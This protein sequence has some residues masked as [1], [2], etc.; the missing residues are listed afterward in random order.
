MTPGPVFLTGATGFTGARLLD[1]MLEKEIPLRALY[2]NP[3][4][5]NELPTENVDW[6]AGDL[7]NV[8]HLT[9]LMRG[10]SA[11]INIASLGFG[12][13]P[14]IVAAAQRAG[15]RRAIF[16][17]T[18]AVFT[19]LNAASKSVRL[20]AE[21]CIRASE[22]DWTILRPTMIYGSPLDR[23]IW[24]LIHWLR[25]LPVLPILGDGTRLM[26]PIFVDDLAAAIA[27]CLENPATIHKIYNLAGLEPLTY[28]EIVQ[29][30]AAGLGRKVWLPVIPSMP[31]IAFLRMMERLRLPFPLKSEQVERL[32]EDKAFDYTAAALDFGFAPRSFAAGVREE[33]E[34][35]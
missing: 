10:C 16:I 6:V 14:G 24:R 8:G 4:R 21:D 12:H 25:R 5:L 17:G 31:V 29:T 9:E 30:V 13:A 2:R 32:N 26:Q 28:R 18:T 22:L 20:A 34:Y 23:N 27:S 15:L 3:Q 11:L 19:R 1:L 33:L 7:E 35:L